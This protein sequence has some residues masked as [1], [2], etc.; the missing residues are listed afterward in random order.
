MNANNV[1]TMSLLQ[2]LNGVLG[3]LQ[4][5][6]GAEP[7]LAAEVRGLRCRA[8]E[9]LTDLNS[10]NSIVLGYRSEALESLDWLR[11]TFA[12]NEA[13]TDA[14]LQEIKMAME[15]AAQRIGHY[16]RLRAE[17]E[18]GAQCAAG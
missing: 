12:R 3:E 18:K 4:P 10:P 11:D 9:L 17:V 5:L 8:L 16:F 15:M 1:K 7:K 13:T 6:T 14:K 2:D